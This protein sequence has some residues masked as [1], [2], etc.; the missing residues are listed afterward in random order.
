MLIK[1]IL[2][3]IQLHHGF[4]YGA[5]RWVEKAAHSLLE[6]DIRPR[7][8]SQPI[9]S[10]C[11]HPVPGYD[12]LPVRRFEFVLLWGIALYAMRRVDCSWCH[13]VKVERANNRRMSRIC[14]EW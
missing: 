10:G 5:T 11:G 4:V 9:C 14:C 3:R 13:K 8:G 2:N 12:T 7:I 1:S 6:I